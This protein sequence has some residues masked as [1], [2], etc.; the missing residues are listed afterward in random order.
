MFLFFIHHL[1]L[2]NKQPAYLWFYSTTN[3][4]VCVKIIIVSLIGEI[5]KE[6]RNCF[7]SIMKFNFPEFI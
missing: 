2:S 6:N 4:L 7:I 3:K 1:T 5:R